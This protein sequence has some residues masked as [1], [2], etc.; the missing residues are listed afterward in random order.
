MSTHSALNA[1]TAI[2]DREQHAKNP[3]IPVPFNLTKLRP[4]MIPLPQVIK[5]EVIAIPIP[6]NLNRVSLADVEAHK[7]QRRI[8]TTDAI[9]KEYENNNKQRFALAT[10]VRPSASYIEQVKQDFEKEF[11]KELKFG[12]FK[13]RPMPDFTTN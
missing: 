9:R 6:K 4:K 5:R 12:D 3:T 11:T 7:K 10:E 1:S 13:P 8:A 2:A